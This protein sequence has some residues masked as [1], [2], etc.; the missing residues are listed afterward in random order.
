MEQSPRR[1]QDFTEWGSLQ[2]ETEKDVRTSQKDC[3]NM[4]R[5]PDME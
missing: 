5:I 2:A 4:E 3:G 1:H